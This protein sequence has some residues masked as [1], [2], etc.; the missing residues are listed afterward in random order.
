M[1]TEDKPADQA[2]D[3]GARDA[4][5]G[6]RKDTDRLAA[7]DNEPPKASHDESAEE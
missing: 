4:E 6:R 3:D 7:R 2:A 1:G 5:R